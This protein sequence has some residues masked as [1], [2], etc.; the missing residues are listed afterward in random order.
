MN[1]QIDQIWIE[2]EKTGSIIMGE[3]YVDDNS[4]VIVTFGDKTRY[5]ATFFTY[6]NIRTITSKNKKTGESLGGKYFWASDMILID[7]IRRKSI[8]LVI[9]DLIETNDF[10]KVSKKID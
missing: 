5:V 8:E 2:S 10:Y 9:K 3:K 4:D 6:E 1:P 7:K